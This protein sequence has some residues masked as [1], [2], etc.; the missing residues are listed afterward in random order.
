MSQNLRAGNLKII[1][2]FI[3][4]LIIAI[5]NLYISISYVILNMLSHLILTTL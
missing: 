2:Q 5:L 4:E 3:K 1:E